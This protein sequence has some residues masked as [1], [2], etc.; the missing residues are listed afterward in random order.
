MKGIDPQFRKDHMYVFFL[1]EVKETIE[2]KR[3]QMAYL[4]QAR[5]TPNMTK[6]SLSGARYQSLDRYNRTYPVFKS[7]RG[8]AP[9][10]EAAKRNLM[11][12]IRQK[13]APT[14]FITLS[15]A[16]Y[17][18]TGLLK[19]IYETVN[20]ERVTDEDIKNMSSKDKRAY[21][22]ENV[23]QAT[24]HFDKRVNKMVSMIMSPEFL[25]TGK[26]SSINKDSNDE[27]E[28]NPSY[29]Y[30]IE[31]QAR[32]APHVH[33]MAWLQ[34]KDG[35]PCPTILAP[36]DDDIET[37][38]EQIEQYTDRIISCESFDEDDNMEEWQKHVMKYQSHR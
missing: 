7:M 26:K 5:N 27:Y 33:M 29:F 2:L 31:F 24:L 34:N 12:A 30:R 8:T 3:C 18:W 4:K 14:L 17:H 36:G 15:A 19:A 10:F 21:I 37:R 9:Y 25:E 11:A 16:E 38:C 1:F 6:Q 20:G 35:S 32:G 22:N 23:V 28:I 13:G